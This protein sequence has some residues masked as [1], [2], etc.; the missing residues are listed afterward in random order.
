MLFR[1]A[2]DWAR[3]NAKSLG[4]D[5]KRVAVGGD[6]AGGYLSA[7]ICQAAKKAGKPQ[8]TLQLLIYPC[9]DWTAEGGTMVSMANAYPLTKDMMD[10]MVKKLG[11]PFP[12]PKYFQFSV[13][14]IGAG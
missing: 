6:S 4:A 12:F 11:R 9:T 3:E 10:W 1:S 2:Y 7:V 5:G 13:P 8:P 14:A